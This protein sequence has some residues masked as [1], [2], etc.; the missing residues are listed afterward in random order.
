MKR[1]PSR[2]RRGLATL[3]AITLCGGIGAT[4]ATSDGC[5]PSPKNAPQSAS[6]VAQ[7]R[8]VVETGSD[9]LTAEQRNISQRV[10]LE[11]APGSI[12]HLYVISAYSGD[13]ILYS[14][15][16]GKVTSSGK[17]LTPTTVAA[18]DGQYVDADHQGIPVRIGGRNLRTTEVL[19]DDGTYGSS[20][21]RYLY[22]FDVRGNY[23]QHYVTGGAMVHISDVPIAWPK[24]ILNLEAS[25]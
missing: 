7:A 25:G 9:G 10:Q 13:V 14:T 19:Q 17:R 5:A 1:R 18:S 16:D 3:G 22:W 12:K 8:V 21:P 2:F 20:E 15:V 24:V 4:L 6:G 11:S 23:H